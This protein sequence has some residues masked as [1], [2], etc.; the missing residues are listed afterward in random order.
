MNTKIL[1]LFLIP[2]LFAQVYVAV[3][4]L[5]H[6]PTTFAVNA[7]MLLTGTTVYGS[8]TDSNGNYHEWGQYT[9]TYTG[10]MTAT[11]TQYYYVIWYADGTMRL[12]G[13]GFYDVSAMTTPYGTLSGRFAISIYEAYDGVSL[14]S[15]GWATVLYGTGGLRGLQGTGVFVWYMF[16]SYDQGDITYTLH[17]S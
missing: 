11:K 4:V 13:M 5:A 8:Y 6:R 14:T 10:D 12:W 15:N 17:F 7:H 2:L 1:A 16:G 9:L 3:P